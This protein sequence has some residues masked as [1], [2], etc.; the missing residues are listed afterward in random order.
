MPSM[1]DLWRAQWSVEP[2]TTDPMAPF[3]LVGISTGDSEGNPDLASFRWSQQANYGVVPNVRMPN[4]FM[5]RAYD[6]ADVWEG[7]GDKAAGVCSGCATADPLYN[8]LQPF[9]MGPGI[10]P[11]LKKPVG[12]RL[13]VGAMALAYGSGQAVTGPTVTGCT[14]SASAERGATL[15]VTFNASLLSGGAQL[16]VLAYDHAHPN[17][18]AFAALINST[19]GGGTWVPLNIALSGTHTVSVDTG[20]LNGSTPLAIKYAWGANDGR[21]GDGDANCCAAADPKSGD[22]CLPGGCPIV[23]TGVAGAPFNGLPANPFLAKIISGK[24]LCPA[25]QTCDE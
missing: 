24:C 16:S 6:L 3:G 21:P 8:C 12:Q 1:I 2:G 9:Y 10:H 7:C 5:A 25:P 18:S 11:R 15:T 22:E 23:A 19:D 14:Y 20:P 4:V 17:R 13:A